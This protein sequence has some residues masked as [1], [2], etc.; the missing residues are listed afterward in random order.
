M[1]KFLEI[2]ELNQTLE[3]I[4]QLT[5]SIIP[6]LEKNQKIFKTS[7][8]LLKKWTTTQEPISKKIESINTALDI[9]LNYDSTI[10]SK[11]A[12]LDKLAHNH[13][14]EEYIQCVNEVLKMEKGLDYKK[15]NSELEKERKESIREDLRE[16]IKTAGQ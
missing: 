4:D 5:A 9:S 13:S 12:K 15:P 2:E 7:S 10:R 16:K 3:G 6:I 14:T 8:T 11:L 1:S